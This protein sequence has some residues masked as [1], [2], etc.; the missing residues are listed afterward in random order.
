MIA[1]RSDIAPGLE[2]NH[3]DGIRKN[4]SPSNLETVTH[5]QNMI[6]GCRVLGRKGKSASGETNPAAR[7]RVSDVLQIRALAGKIPQSQMAAMFHVNQG[8]ISAVITKKSWAH[9]ESR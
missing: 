8:T 9:L 3:K 6:H 4:T 1:N 7:L 5:S 2:I